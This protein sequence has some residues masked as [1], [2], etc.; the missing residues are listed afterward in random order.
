MDHI[1]LSYR[2]DLS[3][4]L[5]ASFKRSSN[6]D[7]PHRLKCNR[8]KPCQNCIVRGKEASQS[9][10]YVGVANPKAPPSINVVTGNVDVKC[11]IDRLENLV[12]SMI[13][14]DNCADSEP[15]SLSKSSAS[16]RSDGLSSRTKPLSLNN[17]T[18]SDTL[19]Q[20]NGVSGIPGGQKVSTDTR[21]THWDVI[22]NDVSFL[23]QSD[24]L[25][26]S[27]LTTYSTIV[28]MCH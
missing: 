5:S 17:G 4:S 28:D 2:H 3:T 20:R 25:T 21:S 13:S 6:S 7:N 9:C 1:L 14:G 23:V 24:T 27:M 22:L 12:R 18:Y 16:Q 26:C 10:S 8:E 19:S 15:Q 11:R